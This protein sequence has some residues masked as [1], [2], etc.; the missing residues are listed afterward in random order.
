[1]SVS[2]TIIVTEDTASPALADL[3]SRVTPE[4][5]KAVIGPAIN[6]LTQ[7]HLVRRPTNKRGWP[8][9]HFWARAARA[10]HWDAQ[11]DGVTVSINQ[12][13]V[14]QRYHGGPIRPVN[15]RAL[16]IPIS[17]EAY[18]KT[19]SDFPDAFMIKTRKGAYLVQR[20][21]TTSAKTGRTIKRTGRGVARKR[22]VAA[23]EFLFKLSKGVTQDPDPDVIP[24]DEAYLDTAAG[25]LRSSLEGGN[26]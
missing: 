9:T 21:E 23:L 10:T 22:V 6:R 25:A 2:Q 13:G 3:Q 16:T 17:P 7:D 4:R 12:I 8:S 20:G 5:M 19:A 14:R 18:G 11:P 24:S 26:S 15:R 1:M